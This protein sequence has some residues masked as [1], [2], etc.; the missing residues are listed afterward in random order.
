MAE[1]ERLNFDAIIELGKEKGHLTLDEI[2]ERIPANTTVPEME[3]LLEELEQLNISVLEEEREKDPDEELSKD[4]PSDREDFQDEQAMADLEAA[5]IDDP[6]RLYLMEMGKV[7]LLTRDEEV[8]LAKQIEH[9]RHM[10]TKSISRA[11]VTGEQIREIRNELESNGYN[12]N[13]LLRANIDGANPDERARVVKRTLEQ[14]DAVIAM[15]QVIDDGLEQVED[16]TMSGEDT[17]PIEAHIHEHREKIYNKLL[18]TDLNF[19]IIEQ[20][21]AKIRAVFTRIDQANQEIQA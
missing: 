5:K 20:I 2:N 14:L 18:E 19:A 8:T 11:S 3:L 17:A 4:E 1:T 15:Y 7:P 9:G 13:D 10:I 16:A 6:V 21:A 12:L